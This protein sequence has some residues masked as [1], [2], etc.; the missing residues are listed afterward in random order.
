MIKNLDVYDTE[1]RIVSIAHC[2]IDK[3]HEMS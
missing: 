2:C 1:A 3:V